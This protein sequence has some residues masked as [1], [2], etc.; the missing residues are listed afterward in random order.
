MFYQWFRRVLQLRVLLAHTTARQREV[1]QCPILTHA[2]TVA[3]RRSSIRVGVSNGACIR[4]SRC[5]LTRVAAGPKKFEAS[6]ATLAKLPTTARDSPE[7]ELIGS[8]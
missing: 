4:S 5:S 3:N 1:M 2:P 7:A 8:K 6:C